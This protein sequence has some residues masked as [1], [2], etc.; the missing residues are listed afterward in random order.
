MNKHTQRLAEIRR[1]IDLTLANP[2]WFERLA[3]YADTG[4]P[5]PTQSGIKS[6]SH[7]STTEARALGPADYPTRLYR[8][9]EHSL[10]II[11]VELRHLERA[12]AWTITTPEPPP[13]VH[14]T[15]PA[16][17]RPITPP[18]KPRHGRCPKCA[19]HHRRHGTEW[20]DR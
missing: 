3:W 17:T 19:Q 10:E 9:T 12:H 18:D 20:P 15:N 1:L 8:N 4:A 5:S 14:C 6:R 16:C 2:A 7:N 13:L 11:L